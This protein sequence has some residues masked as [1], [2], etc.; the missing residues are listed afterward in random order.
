MLDGYDRIGL[1]KENKKIAVRI[2]R[3]E[4]KFDRCVLWAN[5]GNL[6]AVPGYRAFAEI[7]IGETVYSLGS[8]HGIENTF[9]DGLL[10]GKRWREGQPYLQTSAPISPGSSGGGLFDRAGQLLGI[11]TGGVGEG[12]NLG[13]AIPIDSFLK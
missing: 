1:V 2:H 8:P 12:T 11:T 7:R 6:Q 13:F 3:V 5:S 4:R 10:S 9:A